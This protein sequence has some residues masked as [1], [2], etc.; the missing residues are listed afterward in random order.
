MDIDT[1]VLTDNE[2]EEILV[3]IGF[4]FFKAAEMEYTKPQV[5]TFCAKPALREYYRWNPKKLLQQT[6][7]AD[8]FTVAFPNDTVV[9]V[10]DA[11]FSSVTDSVGATATGNPFVDSYT[12]K[13]GSAWGGHG[14]YGTP[15]DY[16]SSNAR[17]MEFSVRQSKSELGRAIKIEVDTYARTIT[18]YVNVLGQL[19]IT[20]ATW[21]NI[22]SHIPF[23]DKT[24]VIEYAQSI[25]LRNYVMLMSQMDSDVPNS[26][27]YQSLMNESERLRD[28]VMEIWKTKTKP[29]V[30][31]G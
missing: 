19:S 11:R 13:Q 24:N 1:V 3:A 26:F 14:L 2:Y 21:D 16:D 6:Q 4:P 10:L 30:I 28:K 20:W 27:N 18:G 17:R 31:R 25:L 29:V 8:S 23:K 12:I 7:V 22:F 5:I 9:D 15:Y